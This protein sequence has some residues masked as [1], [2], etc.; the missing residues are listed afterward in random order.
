[1]LADSLPA[2]HA[3]RRTRRGA[4]ARGAAR[5]ALTIFFRIDIQVR[6]KNFRTRRIPIFRTRFR[7]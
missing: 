4:N 3:D 6:L 1:M 7:A 5:L 2:D